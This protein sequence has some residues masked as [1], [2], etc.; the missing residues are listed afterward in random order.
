MSWIDGGG[1]GVRTLKVDVGMPMGSH[2]SATQ[3][4][5]MGIYDGMSRMTGTR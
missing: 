2:S 5:R 1:G 4:S 3:F